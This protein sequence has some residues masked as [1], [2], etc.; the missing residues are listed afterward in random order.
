MV[1]GG[2][3]ISCNTA[4]VPPPATPDV[5]VAEFHGDYVLQV[6]IRG[7]ICRMFPRL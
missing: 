2:V 5:T 1:L 4:A 6:P 3:G 7:I